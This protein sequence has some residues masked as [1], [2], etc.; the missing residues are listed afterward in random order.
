MKMNKS[1]L[2]C[3]LFKHFFLDSPLLLQT[4]VVCFPYSRFNIHFPFPINIMMENLWK[5]IF[6]AE[7]C[8]VYIHNFEF[9]SGKR[10]FIFQI[11]C[12]NARILLRTKYFFCYTMKDAI[13]VGVYRVETRSFLMSGITSFNLHGYALFFLHEFS[14]SCFLV[15]RKVSRT[16]GTGPRSGCESELNLTAF[17]GSVAAAYPMLCRSW[18]KGSEV[19]RVSELMDPFWILYVCQCVSWKVSVC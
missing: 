2:T 12:Y 16:F 18:R 19:R 6:G 8:C 17:Q 4:V 9:H 3:K 15:R 13:G 14:F 11:T 5:Q 7:I 1:W 10:T